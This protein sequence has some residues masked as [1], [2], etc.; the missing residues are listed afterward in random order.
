MLQPA[1]H[2]V[3]FAFSTA[4]LTALPSAQEPKTGSDTPTGATPPTTPGAAPGVAGVPGPAPTAAP[5]MSMDLMMI[6]ALFVVVMLFMSMR[7]DS[8][9]RKEQQAMLSSIKQGDRIVTTGGIHGTVHRLDEKTVT[10]LLDTVQVTFERSAIGRVQ[11][12]DA[13][14]SEAKRA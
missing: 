13:K 6:M 14:L 9:A 1:T 7:R 8:K 11:R 5:G 4:C 10:L 2:H 3:P 12:D